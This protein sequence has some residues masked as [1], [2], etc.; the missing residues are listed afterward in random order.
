[1]W[2][3]VARGLAAL[4]AHN[5]WA[6]VLTDRDHGVAVTRARS[7][8]IGKRV[9][10]LGL[11]FALLT[12][13]WIAIDAVT[14]DRKLWL[15]LALGRVVAGLAFVAIAMHEHRPFDPRATFVWL[16]ALFAV[17]AC[18]FVYSQAVLASAPALAMPVMMT[19]AYEYLPF[20]VMTALAIFPLTLRENVA[21][22]G[23]L[24]VLFAAG[25][26]IFT[27]LDT[28]LPQAGVLDSRGPDALS[29]LWPLVLVTGVAAIAGMSQLQFLIAATEQSSRDGLTGLYTR[30]FGEQILQFQFEVAKRS[31]AALSAIFVDLDAFKCV[32]DR[33]G[34]DCG[35]KVLY[36]AAQALTSTLRQQDIVVRWGGEEFLVLMPNTNID[37]AF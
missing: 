13:A 11:L 14:F 24:L 27:G 29:I 21:L 35:D 8:L 28:R 12:V 32:N 25:M 10:S 22:G 1:M 5:G 23:L 15:P 20:I 18:F 16:S 36:A 19:A 26:L 3:R 4:L 33:Y 2:S 30:R 17:P 37:E 34:H 6:G 9:H 31:G 7:T